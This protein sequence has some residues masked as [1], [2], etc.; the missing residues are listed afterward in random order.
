MDREDTSPLV[1]DHEYEFNAKKHHIDTKMDK[2][3]EKLKAFMATR[4][5][6]SSSM[7][8][9]SCAHASEKPFPA[10]HIHLWICG[11]FKR[12]GPQEKLPKVKSLTSTSYSDLETDDKIPFY[13]TQDPEEYLE[14]ERK[15]DF[16]L[17]LHLVPSED[18]VKCATR[19]FHD[20]Y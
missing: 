6:S 7:R 9:R 10:R 15:M 5:R 2:H 4:K 18:Q 1:Y 11:I 16:Y 19:N 13:G 20:N 17:K 8:R 12:Q 3:L 14:W